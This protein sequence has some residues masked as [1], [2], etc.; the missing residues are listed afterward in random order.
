MLKH[1]W[2]LGQI[3]SALYVELVFASIAAMAASFAVAYC[4]DAAGDA[5]DDPAV[6]GVGL[7]LVGP[8]P[9]K[10]SKAEDRPNTRSKL[11]RDIFAAE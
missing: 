9:V 10:S 4:T 1:V 7:P 11:E 6:A 5:D 8:Q 3:P 2:P